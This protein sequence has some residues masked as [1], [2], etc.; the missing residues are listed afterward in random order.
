MVDD[1]RNQILYTLDGQT[2]VHVNENLHFKIWNQTATQ[3]WEQAEAQVRP[4]V[5]QHLLG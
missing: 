5:R 2:K 3:I 4:H 1:I